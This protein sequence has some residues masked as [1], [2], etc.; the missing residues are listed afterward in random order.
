MKSGVK[1]LIRMNTIGIRQRTTVSAAARRCW[2]VFAVI[3]ACGI[4]SPASAHDGPEHE[5]EELSERIKLE[6][7]SDELLIQRAIEYKVLG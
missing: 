2:I 3:L 7:E 5:I 1:K 6:G 4:T